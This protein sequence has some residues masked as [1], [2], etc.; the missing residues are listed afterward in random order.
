MRDL[1]YDQTLCRRGCII[2]KKR[3]NFLKMDRHKYVRQ[4]VHGVTPITDDLRKGLYREGFNEMQFFSGPNFV[5]VDTPFSL[6]DGCLFAQLVDLFDRGTS[7]GREGFSK[8]YE[9][10]WSDMRKCIDRCHKDGVIKATVAKDPQKFITY[11]PNIFPMLEAF[12]KSGKTVFLLTNSLWDYTQVVMNYLEGR[13]TGSSK[14]LRWTA[15][16][17]LIITGGNK[18]AFLED[19]GSLQL[20]RVDPVCTSMHTERT[21]LS[22]PTN[23]NSNPTNAKSNPTNPNSNPTNPK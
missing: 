5:S 12:Q 11:D 23:P 17:D 13:K 18:P 2:D 16:F 3:G 1:D 7:M 10:L 20:F 21:L 6:V 9:K 14:D 19:E 15:Y 4:A 8:S 22:N